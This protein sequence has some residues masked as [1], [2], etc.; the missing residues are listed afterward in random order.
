MKN[1]FY[2]L[3]ALSIFS[4]NTFAKENQKM[5]ATGLEEV[6][7]SGLLLVKNKNP[8]FDSNLGIYYKHP[9]VVYV[10]PDDYNIIYK[11][12]WVKPSNYVNLSRWRFK[13]GVKDLSK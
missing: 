3:L 13:K 1:L 10:V 5:S 7:L 2:I 8:D 12:K 9:S 6:L 4:T 11:R